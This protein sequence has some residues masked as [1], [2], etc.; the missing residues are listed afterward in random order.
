MMRRTAIAIALIAATAALAQAARLAPLPPPLAI[1]RLPWSFDGWRGSDAGDLDEESQR[2]LAADAYINRTYTG[3][4]GAPVGLYAAY[5]AMQRPGVSVHSPLHCLPGTGWEPTDVGSLGGFKRM[6]VRKDRQV[7]VVLYWYAIHGRTV[8]DE[9]S[10]KA[11]LLH[12]SIRYH[13]SD[14]ALF[15]VVVPVAGSVE[16]AEREGL[17]FARALLPHVSHLWS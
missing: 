11:W 13:R 1:D 10:S 8:G 4:A 15:R 7:A 9:L 14:A 5:Y 16:A 17:A 12:D 2:I 6:V 3:A